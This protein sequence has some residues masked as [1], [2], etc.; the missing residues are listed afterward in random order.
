MK[1]TCLV[2]SGGKRITGKD[3]I[4]KIIWHTWTGVL[5]QEVA[6]IWAKYTDTNDVNAIDVNFEQGVCVTGDDFGLVKLFKYPTFKKGAKFKKYTGHSAHVTNVRFTSDKKRLI[7]VGGA[8]H[9][10]FQWS[11]SSGPEGQNETEEVGTSE[12]LANG[13]AGWSD[14][15]GSDSELSNAGEIDSEIEREAEQSYE[16]FVNK[17]AA[18]HVF[19]EHNRESRLLKDMAAGIP[20]HAPSTGIALEHVFG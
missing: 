9:A 16:R 2:I 10:V 7:T 17:D 14:S 13:V 4:D 20:K 3:E 19:K 8:D 12:S 5:G 18:T 15:E 6:G 1:T 11:F